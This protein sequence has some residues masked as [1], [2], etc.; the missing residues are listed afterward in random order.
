RYKPGQDEE[1]RKY[2]LSM[3]RRL[4]SLG[5]TRNKAGGGEKGRSHGD[6]SDTRPDAGGLLIRTGEADPHEYSIAKTDDE[7]TDAGACTF[8]YFGDSTIHREA[9]V[10][11][12][13]AIEKQRRH[14]L[15][16]GVLW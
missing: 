3:E 6:G 15:G 12:S 9:R 10:E 16:L 4:E 7:S 11:R 13:K 5:K 14:L 1:S 2:E 8:K